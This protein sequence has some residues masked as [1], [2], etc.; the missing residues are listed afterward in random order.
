MKYGLIGTDVQYSYSKKLHEMMGRDKYELLILKPEQLALFLTKKEFLG[1]NVTMPFKVDCMQYLDNMEQRARQI[2]SV[3]TI[4]NQRG[5]LMGYNTDYIGFMYLLNKNNVDVFGKDCVVMGSGGTSKMIRVALQNKGAGRVRYCSRIKNNGMSYR[6]LANDID[7]QVLINATPVGRYPN[8]EDKP[9][10][11]R[12][13]K[14]LETVI[15]INYDPYTSAL[16]VDAKE[17]G[18]KYVGGID[19]LVMQAGAAHKL[20]TNKRVSDN[21]IDKLTK[22]IIRGSINIVLIGMMGSGKS[23]IGKKLAKKLKKRFVDTD[24]LLEQSAD[25]SI[26]QIINA[27]GI[28]EFRKMESNLIDRCSS[29][30]NAVIATGGGAI[31][32][33]DNIRKLRKNGL[34]VFLNR[35]LD[36][37][38]KSVFEEGNKKRPLAVDEVTYKRLYEERYEKYRMCADIIIEDTDDIKTII[39]E[40]I[41][42][43][44]I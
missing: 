26:A 17:R 20:F 10:D 32:N 14:S 1:I 27:R 30:K 28:D 16:G 41:E 39:K 24:D 25:A 12:E 31:E 23:T 44:G 33:I 15:D 11:I 6:D 43:A 38:I 35:D 42:K 22:K 5:F 18:L 9:V 4:I 40:I 8:I 19:M 2:G 37:A 13:M 21:E 7:V 29:L 3:N 36:K 34:I